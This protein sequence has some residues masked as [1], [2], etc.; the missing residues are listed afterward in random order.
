LLSPR[1]VVQPAPA[2]AIAKGNSSVFS[3]IKTHVAC[4]LQRTHDTE[5]PS[6]SL[7]PAATRVMSRRLPANVFLA[8]DCDLE[9]RID[10]FG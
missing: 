9:I 8:S 10:E 1:A 3:F 6:L 4:G 5:T 7:L 2:T